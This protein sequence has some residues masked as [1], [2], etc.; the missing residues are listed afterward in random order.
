MKKLYLWSCIIALFIVY[1]FMCIYIS[2]AFGAEYENPMSTYHD[3][4]FVAGD[5]EDQVKIQLSAKYNLF[6]P[7]H[8]GAYFG[9]EQMSNWFVYKGRDTFYTMYQPEAFYRF[10]S[11]KNIFKD[12]VISGVDYIQFSPI[13]H[14]STGVEGEDHRSINQAYGQIQ[15]SVGEVYNVGINLKGFRYYT[16]DEQNRDI[17]DYKKFYEAEAF[18]KIRSKTVEYL[19]KE[20]VK[21]KITGNP[22]GKG[23][24]EGTL[25]FRLISS[26]IQ[27]RLFV[28]YFRGYGEFM[29]NYNKKSEAIRAGFV[30]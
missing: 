23:S 15:L 20:E 4:Y 8:A 6:Y 3:N 21:V 14:C 17:N 12:Y 11:G 28:Q 13:K 29:V 26:K 18:F 24:I 9:Y 16:R 22:I 7:S 2:N 1:S 10:E 19:D 30:F 25:T 5:V 27:P